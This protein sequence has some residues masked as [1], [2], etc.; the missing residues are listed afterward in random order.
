MG[1][2]GGGERTYHID[3]PADGKGAKGGDVMTKTHAMGSAVQY[4]MRYLLKM[5]FNIAIGDDD[6]DGNAAGGQAAAPVKVINKAQGAA[7]EALCRDTN[8]DL[9]K[10]CQSYGCGS[11]ESFPAGKYAEIEGILSK[12][13]AAINKA[14]ADDEE[15][16]I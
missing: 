2:E 7:L 14:D 5:I 1:H 16:P 3:M 4:G 12:R 8:T 11:L 6:D 9:A 15:L 13:L 10:V